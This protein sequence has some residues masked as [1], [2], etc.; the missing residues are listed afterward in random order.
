MAS[1]KRSRD[2]LKRGP[3]HETDEAAQRILRSLLPP[4]WIINELPRDYGKDY[5]VEIVEE[6]TGRVTG[7]VFYVQLKGA[8]GADYRFGGTVVAHQV[9]LRHLAY[10]CDEVAMPVF[11]VVVD[12]STS[13]GYWLFVQGWLANRKGWRRKKCSTLHIPVDND[14]A[15]FSRFEAAVGEAI[16]YMRST[17]VSLP[18][19]VKFEVERLESLDPRFK[20]LP[21]ITRDKA[22]FCF[23]PLQEIDIT[24]HFKGNDPTFAGRVDGLI[25]K[26]QATRF[27]PGEL[28]V[29]GSLL[30]EK[31]NELGGTVRVASTLSASATLTCIDA[32]GRGVSQPL[33][34]PGAIEGGLGEQHFRSDQADAPLSIE[35]GPITNG[36]GRV[37]FHSDPAVW[38]GQPLLLASYFQSTMCFVQ[39][40]LEYKRFAVECRWQGNTVFAAA[41]ALDGVRDGGEFLAVMRT[42]EKARQVARHYGISPIHPGSALFNDGPAA[43][44]EV[45]YDI[46][47]NGRHEFEAD[48]DF[49]VTLRRSTETGAPDWIATQ[50]T[51]ELYTEEDFC[52]PFMGRK[53]PV[54]PLVI[55]V[56]SAVVAMS[57][58]EVEQRFASG[59]ECVSLKFTCA[60][61]TTWAMRRPTEIEAEAIGHEGQ[62]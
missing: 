7:G 11:F 61:G 15:N 55:E 59:D 14:L 41:G 25:N 23:E 42:M 20:V 47:F 34:I 1:S 60:E 18:D 16:K 31:F 9:P 13:K 62:S 46:I 21:T 10:F 49:N 30:F 3:T 12:T 28:E 8:R 56:P 35:L 58:G 33:D 22:E 5:H 50:H 32:D 36:K 29:E 45:L 52:L 44:V 17:S 38:E 24:L 6:A 19:R 57:A 39:T 43:E 53:L 48:H 2:Y 26:G 51:L 27:A 40:L 54:G 4:R 37:H